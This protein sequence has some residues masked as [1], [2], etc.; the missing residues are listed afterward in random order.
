MHGEPASI[1]ETL[2]KLGNPIGKE[3]SG[4]HDSRQRRLVGEW[5]R[6][7]FLASAAMLNQHPGTD[8]V[9]VERPDLQIREG[10]KL[11]RRQPETVNQVLE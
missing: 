6:D 1:D 5:D 9:T 8:G 10:G 3:P 7:L 4:E 11:L 2:A